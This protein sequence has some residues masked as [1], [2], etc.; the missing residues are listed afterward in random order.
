MNKVIVFLLLAVGLCLSG[1]QA[2]ELG[3]GLTPIGA[4][5]AGNRSGDIP[6]WKGGIDKPVLAM[7]PYR[8]DKPE[9]EIT[10]QDYSKHSNHLTPGQQMLFQ[11]YPTYRMQVYPSRR[12]AAF[13][14]FIYEE[15][16]KNASR[17]SLNEDG[18][19]FKGTVKG[20]PFPK[21]ET[22]AEVMWNHMT[23]Y[24]T[25]GYRGYVNHA[26]VDA[27]GTP[28]IE[29][30]YFEVA[31]RYNR[32]DVTMENF[33][34]EHLFYME[35]TVAPIHKAGNA[36]LVHAPLDRSAESMN[37]W[38]FNPG[39]GR[40][41]RL[42]ATGYDNPLRDGMI[43]IDQVDMFNGSLERYT[44]KLV[45]KQEIY[46][47]YNAYTLYGERYSYE[48]L[49]HKWHLNQDAPRYELHRVWVVEANLKEGASHTY[50]KRVFYVDEDS[51]LI[52]W[53]DLYDRR[54]ELW[55]TSEAHPVNVFFIPFM[56]NAIQV[57]YDLQSRR[58]VVL[59]LTS[60]E[61]SMIEYDWSQPSSYFNPTVLKEFAK[62]IYRIPIPGT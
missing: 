16:V 43:T 8:G 28:N 53:A 32:S 25:D 10:A 14:D 39:L 34:N 2:A 1:T 20:S 23:R 6:D 47:P 24:N 60:E 11:R 46:V 52:L 29:R 37:L 15:T 44:W 45:G 61:P 5:Q 50:S 21:P 27:D 57:H 22:G 12:S 55:R 54:G 62:K 19:G 26:V 49:T 7:N 9:F 58:Y 48:E 33:N 56:T 42:G 30:V 3:G 41:R 18:N 38:V 59:N 17:V 35:K 13:P 4:E 36:Y 40:T 51:W 31:F